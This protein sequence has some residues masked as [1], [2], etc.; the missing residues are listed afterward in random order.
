MSEKVREF[1][2]QNIGYFI[3][4]IVSMVYVLTALISV[5]STNKTIV[6]ILAD[7]MIALLL[8]I[9]INRVFELQGILNGEMSDKM[10]ETS[11]LHSKVVMMITPKID[12]LTAWCVKKNAENLKIQRIKILSEVGLRYDDFFAPD[13]AVVSDFNE[14][15]KFKNDDKKLQKIK[16]KYLKK[17]I[18]LKLTQISAS[19]LTSEGEKESDPYNFGRSKKQFAIQ[20]GT[21]DFISKLL[22]AIL[23]GYYGVELITNFS[24]ANLIW[25]ALQVALFL[26]M[27]AVKMMNSYFF[28][29][30]EFRSKIIKKIDNLQMFYNEEFGCTL[31]SSMASFEQGQK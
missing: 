25:K 9:F 17:A 4:V 5:S 3:V 24:Y 27:G 7:G 19:S 13:G 21:G 31:D 30:D 28:I 16:K 26:I 20:T 8:G 18:K 2:R 15:T 10:R 11:M 22:A 12:K 1:F 23:F 29:V 6:E 14:K